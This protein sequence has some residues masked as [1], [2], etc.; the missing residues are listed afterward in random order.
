MNSSNFRPQSPQIT[1]SVTVDMPR[2]PVHIPGSCPVC[3]ATSWTGTYSCLAWFLCFFCFWN[4]GLCC[5]LCMRQKKCT[6]CG[7][8]V[9]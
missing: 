5:C 7:F 6:K 3:H 4:C 2:G 9:G 1:S 8:T